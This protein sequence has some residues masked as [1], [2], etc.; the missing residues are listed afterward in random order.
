MRILIVDDEFVS[1][2]KMMVLFEPYGE[3]EAATGGVQALK[4]IGD[5]F[6]KGTPYDLIALDIE[7]PGASGLEVLKVIC[8]RE[9]LRSMPVAKKLVVSAVSSRNNVR[10]ALQHKSD[11]FLVK[12]ITRENLAA[13]LTRI[14]FL[15]DP[16]RQPQ[17]AQAAQETQPAQASEEPPTPPVA[18]KPE[19]ASKPQAT[20]A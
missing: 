15:P 6:A 13:T 16:A 14:G 20:P 19:P 11:A 8:Q 3:C 2:T 4:M 5:A 18:Q 1:L 12:P 7:M 17:P 9:Q 10:E